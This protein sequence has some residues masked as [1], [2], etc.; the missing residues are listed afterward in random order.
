MIGQSRN[1]NGSRVTGSPGQCVKPGVW[2]EFEF[3]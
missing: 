1:W 3:Y 2:S